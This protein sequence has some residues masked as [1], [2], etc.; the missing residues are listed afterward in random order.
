MDPKTYEPPQPPLIAQLPQMQLLP[1]HVITSGVEKNCIRLRGLPYEAK[2]EHILHFLDDFA[3]HIIYQGV[4]LVYN[5]QVS[6]CVCVNLAVQGENLQLRQSRTSFVGGL[7]AMVSFLLPRAS[8]T[9][10]PSSRWTRRRPR[11]SRPSR[12]TTRT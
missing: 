12:S 3:N 7:L 4:H 10:K 9:A 2:V 6:L 11:T 8:L 1:Q 5:A